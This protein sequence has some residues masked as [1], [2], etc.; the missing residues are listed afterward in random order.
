MVT[1]LAPAVTVVVALMVVEVVVMTKTIIITTE[2]ELG[3]MPLTETT[4][5]WLIVLA[6]DDETYRIA[7]SRST[8]SGQVFNRSEFKNFLVSF[9]DIAV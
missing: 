8:A 1:R 7:K 4:K 3:S 2:R 5:A 9:L 6:E